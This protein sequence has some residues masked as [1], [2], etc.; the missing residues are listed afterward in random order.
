MRFKGSREILKDLCFLSPQRMMEFNNNN[1]TLPNDAFQN[2]DKWIPSIDVSLLKIEYTTFSNNLTELLEGQGLHPNKLHIDHIADE[3]DLGSVSLTS[4]SNEDEDIEVIKGKVSSLK[5]LEILSNYGLTAA[6]PNLYLAYKSLCTLPAS[7]A[8]AERSFSVVKLVKT[9]LRSTIG[10]SRLESLLILSCE[11]DVAI[12]F[13][14]VI[15]TFGNSSDLL[16]K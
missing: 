13:E 9:R 4:S 8:T 6:F 3:S 14:E 5:I 10:Q 2:I 1:K 12:N 7:S 16:K 11:K 15:D